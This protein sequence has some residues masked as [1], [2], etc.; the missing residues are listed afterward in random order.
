MKGKNRV[1]IRGNLTKDPT[2]SVSK[3]GVKVAWFIIA[4]N[5]RVKTE[6]EKWEDRADFIPVI[7]FRN[8]ANFAEK[9]LIKGSPV[10]AEGKLKT[11]PLQT[12]TAVPSIRWNLW[13][14]TL[15][16]SAV[17]RPPTI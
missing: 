12:E 4:S 7:C 15:P 6:D 2:I 1:I 16:P 11:G 14:T 17:K 5:F 13:P 9:Y 8:N 3:T 10:E